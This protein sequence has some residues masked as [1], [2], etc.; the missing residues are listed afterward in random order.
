MIQVLVLIGYSEN[1]S[2]FLSDTITDWEVFETEEEADKFLEVRYT[3]YAVAWAKHH[4]QEF[5]ANAKY[6]NDSEL[7]EKYPERDEK[8]LYI[9][10][11]N[12]SYFYK[13]LIK[14]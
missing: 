5:D 10:T 13:K 7:W 2:M 11:E 9:G 1:Q 4:K 14:K 6:D 8:G 12:Y 3:S